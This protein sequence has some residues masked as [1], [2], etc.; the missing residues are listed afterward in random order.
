MLVKIKVHGAIFLLR[1]S[2]C[3]RVKPYETPRLGRVSIYRA[4]WSRKHESPLPCCSIQH[5]LRLSPPPVASRHESRCNKIPTISGHRFPSFADISSRWESQAAALLR[6]KFMHMHA[7]LPWMRSFP[8][9]ERDT[10]PTRRGIHVPNL[11]V[12]TARTI[13]IIPVS[14]SSPPLSLLSLTLSLSLALLKK[15]ARNTPRK[16]HPPGRRLF[17]GTWQVLRFPRRMR[18]S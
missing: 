6:L 13:H 5:P 17:R 16:S 14:D 11:C 1:I 2:H 10:S 18:M 9:R 8:A 4:V 15:F 7:T 12:L 3:G